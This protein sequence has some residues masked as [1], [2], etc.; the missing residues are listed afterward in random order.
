MIISN[1]QNEFSGNYQKGILF[2]KLIDAPFQRTNATLTRQD[3]FRLCYSEMSFILY[4][5]V[6]TSGTRSDADRNYAVFSAYII[7]FPFIR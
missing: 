4:A 1:L 5:Y 3:Y 7:S 6:F 2:A